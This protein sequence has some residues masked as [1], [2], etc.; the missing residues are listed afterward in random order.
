[1]STSKTSIRNRILAA[2]PEKDYERLLLQ[3]EPVELAHG[4]VLCEPNDPISHLYFINEGMASLV[5]LTE[6][7]QSIEVGVVGKEG[8]LGFQAIFG[9]DMMQHRALVQIPG[10]ALRVK[11]G[12]VKDELNPPGILHNLLMR[13]NYAMLTQITQ[14]VV[15]NRFHEVEERLARWLLI[16]H[17]RAESDDLP[18]TQEFLSIMLGARRPGVNAA[19]GMLEKGELIHH[20]RG[21]VVVIDRQGLEKVSCECYRIAKKEFDRALGA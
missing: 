19:I 5:A 1:M 20:S 17:D 21:K 14:S 4:E 6:E 13:Y 3:L 10:A 7:G 18:L 2:L 9:G 12:K 8:V 16:C 15:C 11:T